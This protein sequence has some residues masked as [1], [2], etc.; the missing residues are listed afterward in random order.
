L[1]FFFRFIK[2]LETFRAIWILM[3]ATVFTLIVDTKWAI[4]LFYHF[5]YCRRVARIVLS[6]NYA[7]VMRNLLLLKF[8]GIFKDTEYTNITKNTDQ[9]FSICNPV[10]IRTV[11]DR[12][13]THKNVIVNLF[14][15]LGKKVY[16][17][18]RLI[19]N[20]GKV[21]FGRWKNW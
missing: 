1:K 20:T 13:T 12:S 5:P 8:I 2:A 14:L 6:S 17:H 4:N 3:C 18:F 19:P 16:N 11:F 7:Q 21:V 15:G 9:V 10:P